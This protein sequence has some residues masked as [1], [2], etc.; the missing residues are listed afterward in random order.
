MSR[1]PGFPYGLL[2]V[3]GARS[4]Y[5]NRVDRLTHNYLQPNRDNIVKCAIHSG[6]FV[7]KIK[8]AN[9][10]VHISTPRTVTSDGA[11]GL[12]IPRSAVKALRANLA[13]I[14]PE[15]GNK[16]FSGTRLCW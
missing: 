16:P 14:Y 1:I 9:P 4:Q 7:H 11:D 15:I 2:C 6:G 12:R 10:D 5:D 8:S 13:R 3:S